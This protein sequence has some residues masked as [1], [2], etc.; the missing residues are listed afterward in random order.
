MI[1]IDESHYSKK[2]KFSNFVEKY[3]NKEDPIEKLF[4]FVEVSAGY[5]NL[6]SFSINLHVE[7]DFPLNNERNTS[8]INL[9]NKKY[10]NKKK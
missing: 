7:L 5:N 3:N 8:L 1:S 6:Y 4:Q 9:L 10:N 2:N